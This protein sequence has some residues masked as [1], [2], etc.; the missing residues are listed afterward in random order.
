MQSSGFILKQLASQV[1]STRQPSTYL[2]PYDQASQYVEHLL[3]TP[4]SHDSDDLHDTLLTLKN[5]NDELELTDTDDTGSHDSDD[6]AS[7]QGMSNKPREGFLDIDNKLKRLLKDLELLVSRL[8]KIKHTLESDVE[9]DPSLLKDLISQSKR[10]SR[11][12]HMLELKFKQHAPS[13]DRELRKQ[14]KEQLA[15]ANRLDRDLN[16]LYE[17]PRPTP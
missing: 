16:D 8:Q 5:L 11:N 9:H 4:L 15:Q 14:I 13:H 2:Q 10:L 6:G 7:Q 3:T 1:L 12:L 17:A